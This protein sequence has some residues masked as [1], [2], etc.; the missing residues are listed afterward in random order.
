[1]RHPILAR[2]HREPRDD[3]RPVVDRVEF[4]LGMAVVVR[5]P[6]PQTQPGLRGADA[7]EVRREGPIPRRKQ[8]DVGLGLMRGDDRPEV[9]VH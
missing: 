4:K 5:R 2:I 1:M 3:L 8:E 6:L 9:V 7:V